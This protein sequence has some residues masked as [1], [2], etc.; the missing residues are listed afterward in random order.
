[1]SEFTT[2]PNID[3]LNQKAYKMR[4]VFDIAQTTPEAQRAVF[5]GA[6]ANIYAEIYEFLDQ[7]PE[8]I[9]V[10]Q[11]LGGKAVELSEEE[12]I[13][14]SS[15]FE[16]VGLAD[17]GV[18]SAEDA[19]DY[20]F[21]VSYS[22][23]DFKAFHQLFG[24]LF[25]VEE[26]EEDDKE[27]LDDEGLESNALDI[28]EYLESKGITEPALTF[29]RL[30]MQITPVES[31]RLRDEEW[32]FMLL[33]EDEFKEFTIGIGS[34][35][36]RVTALLEEVSLA[37]VW[38]KHEVRKRVSYQ[39]LIGDEAE[40]EAKFDAH[41]ALRRLFG[42]GAVKMMTSER[43]TTIRERIRAD[44][45]PEVSEEDLEE[46]DVV[47]HPTYNKARVMRAI[48]SQIESGEVR[49]NMISRFLADDLRIT[50]LEA[51]QIIR[52]LIGSE[53]VYWGNN[54]AG[55]KTLSLGKVD[56]TKHNVGYAENDLAVDS[57]NNPTQL[58]DGQLGIAVCIFDALLDLGHRGKGMPISRLVTVIN[59][60]EAEI[61][62]VCSRLVRQG[63]LSREE[64][65]LK[66]GK[67][68]RSRQNRVSAFIMVPTDQDWKTLKEDKREYVERIAVA[69]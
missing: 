66:S 57:K 8:I 58:V 46:V 14:R 40:Q 55:T 7:N 50:R 33:S 20:E 3:V 5:S 4:R 1:M 18:I 34:L 41:A 67:S 16:L 56:A 11:D 49:Y 17:Q 39:L 6:L 10:V 52:T 44:Q 64:R 60:E 43:D 31:S 25:E 63:L 22:P 15:H 29:M 32:E 23:E 53:E 51:K 27:E 24:S 9:S 59:A 54:I 42:D 37:A 38:V 13:N 35:G 28:L 19:G 48:A 61:R 2:P 68:P 36:K 26:V 30:A 47:Q 65:K 62:D 45:Q 21:N 12:A 69:E